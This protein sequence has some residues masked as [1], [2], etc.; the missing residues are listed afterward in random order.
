MWIVNVL[1]TGFKQKKIMVDV[2][3]TG[4]EN[5]SHMCGITI[6]MKKSEPII[7]LGFDFL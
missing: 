5:D 6:N 1:V 2:F 7:I 3:Y 4:R